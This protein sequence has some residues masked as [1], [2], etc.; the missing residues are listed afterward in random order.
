MRKEL[1][2]YFQGDGKEFCEMTIAILKKDTEAIKSSVRNL[3]YIIEDE[4]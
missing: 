1:F 3:L 4:I 2:N